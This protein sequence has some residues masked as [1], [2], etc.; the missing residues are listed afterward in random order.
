M[1]D[2]KTEKRQRGVRLTEKRPEGGNWW[3]TPFPR[4]AHDTHIGAHVHAVLN[5]PFDNPFFSQWS[6][7]KFHFFFLVLVL[8]FLALGVV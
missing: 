3:T 4:C 7:C 2:K 5:L 1:S 6:A 8:M